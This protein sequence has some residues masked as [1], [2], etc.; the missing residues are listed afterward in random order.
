MRN[1]VSL[2][3]LFLL[4]LAGCDAAETLLEQLASEAEAREAMSA[5]VAA[6]SDAQP[7][8]QRRGDAVHRAAGDGERIVDISH[9]CPSGGTV[10]FEGTLDLQN[11]GNTG[12]GD[13]FDPSSGEVPTGVGDPPSVGFSYEVRFEGCTVDEVRLDGRLRYELETGWDSAGSQFDATWDYEG[14]VDV[15]GSV[16]GR[17]DFSFGGTGIAGLENWASGIPDG[18]DG[19]AC[20]FEAAD[21]DL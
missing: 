2:G 17:C 21:L 12:L 7:S 3:C 1:V 20:G 11:V 10:H 14:S 8:S 13:D 18:F 5:M 6:L 19:D 16:E 9:P 4:P 15:S